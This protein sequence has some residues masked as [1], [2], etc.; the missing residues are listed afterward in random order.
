MLVYYREDMPPSP[1]SLPNNENSLHYN[2]IQLHGNQPN[3]KQ[4]HTVFASQRS[5]NI[6]Y[7]RYCTTLG[8]RKKETREKK[9]HKRTI[10]HGKRCSSLAA[11]TG[12][13][14]RPCKGT[15]PS[16]FCCRP[17]NNSCRRR[18]SHKRS[19]PEE[20]SQV[21]A[22][23]PHYW[24]WYSSICGTRYLCLPALTEI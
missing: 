10:H 17:V 2:S 8:R 16:L 23:H 9:T 14:H 15:P 21:V 24:D 18:H 13:I 3:S 12:S 20:I 5:R 1:P 22:P 6:G 19:R 11:L 4:S 7:V